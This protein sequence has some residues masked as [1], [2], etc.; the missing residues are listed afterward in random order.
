[1]M[2][3]RKRITGRLEL[4]PRGLTLVTESGERWVLDG[5]EPDDNLIGTEVTAEG[6]VSGLD[7][8][9][10]DWIGAATP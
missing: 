9:R 6:E 4:G 5:C 7:R 2:T 8:L 3:N 1:M 10:A